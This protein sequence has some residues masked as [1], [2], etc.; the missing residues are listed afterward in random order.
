M[1]VRVMFIDINCQHKLVLIVQKFR[2]DLL[3]DFKRPFRSDL[4]R[5]EA[6]NKVL[7]EDGASA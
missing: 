2:A 1:Q 5:L 7:G 4:T 3:A 6:D